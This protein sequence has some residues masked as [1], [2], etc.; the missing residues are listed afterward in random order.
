MTAQITIDDKQYLLLFGYT[1]YKL[2]MTGLWKFKNSYMNSEGELTRLGL[3]RLF[4]NAYEDACMDK[5]ED[6]QLRYN[7]IA[8]W[9]DKQYES[10]EGKQVIADLCKIWVQTKEVKQLVDDNEK[11]NQMMEANQT[12]T[13]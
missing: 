5:N 3:S 11:K 4:L 12:L 8:E 1:C 6:V 7:D 9:V 10:E 13:A 2:F